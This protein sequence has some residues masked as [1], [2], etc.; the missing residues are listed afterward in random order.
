[1]KPINKFLGIYLLNII[2]FGVWFVS[3]SKAQ[4]ISISPKPTPS[5]N[6]PSRPIFAQALKAFGE[7]D[8][9][10]AAEL[11]AKSAETEGRNESDFLI[12]INWWTSRA[13]GLDSNAA[14]SFKYLEKAVDLGYG[15]DGAFLVLALKLDFVRNIL[16]SNPK[17]ND[18]VERSRNNFI[19]NVKEN[20]DTLEVQLIKV[21]DQY[22]RN[23]LPTLVEENPNNSKQIMLN[24]YRGDIE[25]QRKLKKLIKAKK[26]KTYNDYMAA[27]LVFQH[28][29]NLSDLKVANRLAR[30]GLQLAQ[31]DKQK[32][33]AG[34]FIG[35]TTDRFLWSQ[36]K[37][38]IYGTQSRPENISFKETL[39]IIKEITETTKKGEMPKNLIAPSK[40]A[41]M[42]KEPFDKTKVA[43]E[44]RKILCIPTI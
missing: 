17:W 7:K 16:Y 37:P 25:R 36:G 38:Q 12:T 35:A 10:L 28:S 34:W 15:K 6:Q 26:I 11:G 21:E 27:A 40:D 2:I 30:Q 3:H 8:Y 44:E 13:Y 33:K 41:K 43:N 31:D 4:N 14:N 1:M 42:T 5:D 29:G 39:K 32:C 22:A 20:G 18:L 9:K 19:K 24:M 23:W